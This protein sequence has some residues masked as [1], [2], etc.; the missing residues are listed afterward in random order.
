MRDWVDLIL[1][2]GAAEGFWPDD[3]EIV[4]SPARHRPGSSEVMAL[5]V[6]HEKLTAETGWQPRVSWEDGVLQ[7]IRWYAENRGR[8]IGRVDWLPTGAPLTTP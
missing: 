6:G 5:R 8:W 4:S 1:R 3:R 2:I 7:T